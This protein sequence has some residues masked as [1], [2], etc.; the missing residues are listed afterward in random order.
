VTEFGEVRL[1]AAPL[2]FVV[3][4]ALAR[5]NDLIADDAIITELRFINYTEHVG[6]SLEH[7][8]VIIQYQRA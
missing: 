5:V 6:G 3:E 7:W 4:S 1:Y 2:P 8:R